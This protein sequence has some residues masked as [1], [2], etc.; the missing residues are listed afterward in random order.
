MIPD[1]R[2]VS[3]SDERLSREL[4]KWATGVGN[5]KQARPISVGRGLMFGKIRKDSKGLKSSVVYLYG[6]PIGCLCKM[7]D[8]ECFFSEDLMEYLNLTCFWTMDSYKKIN[9]MAMFVK[10]HL[11]LRDWPGDVV[12]ERMARGSITK[13]FD[14]SMISEPSEWNYLLPPWHRRAY[15]WTKRLWNKKKT[16]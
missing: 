5:H 6:N 1:S 2:T 15:Y 12:A 7:P 8:G 3:V 9:V 11:G 4:A 14:E 13:N 10:R 16:T